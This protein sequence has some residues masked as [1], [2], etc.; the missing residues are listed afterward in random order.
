MHSSDSSSPQEE[1]ASTNQSEPIG[2]N[3]EMHKEND[4][5]PLE[6]SK[7]RPFQIESSGYTS[8]KHQIYLEEKSKNL[9]IPTAKECELT[10]KYMFEEAVFI[11]HMC[12][13][14][15]VLNRTQPA[16]HIDEDY[17]K[18]VPLPPSPLPATPTVRKSRKSKA[19]KQWGVTLR[20]QRATCCIFRRFHLG[21]PS[22]DIVKLPAFH[23]HKQEPERRPILQR[24][25]GVSGDDVTEELNDSFLSLRI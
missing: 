16:P 21:R 22:E 4:P 20:E 8:K 11:L 7:N 12:Y 2:P 19:P 13:N 3:P 9:Q 5:S 1:M 24:Q 14:C 6:M 15:R 18:I 23:T 25:F 10:P 17:Q